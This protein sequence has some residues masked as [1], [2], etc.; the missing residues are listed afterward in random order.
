MMSFTPTACVLLLYAEDLLPLGLG[1]GV[2]ASAVLLTKGE[3]PFSSA[4]PHS[5]VSCGQPRAGT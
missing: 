4:Q 1:V 5:A 3:G 2:D